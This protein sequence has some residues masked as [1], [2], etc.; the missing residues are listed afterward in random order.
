M[1]DLFFNHDFASNSP[2]F[3]NSRFLHHIQTVLIIGIIASMI[4]QEL[5]FIFNVEILNIA[6]I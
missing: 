4:F 2:V 1:L 3:N 5:K 6:F